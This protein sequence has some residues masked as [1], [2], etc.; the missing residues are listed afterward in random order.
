[1]SRTPCRLA[2]RWNLKSRPKKPVWR[3]LYFPVPE[4]GMAVCLEHNGFGF[5]KGKAYRFHTQVRADQ[6]P[7][8]DVVTVTKDD[9]S[10]DHPITTW[11]F[12]NNQD[13]LFRKSFQII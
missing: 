8:Y 2:T 12:L 9:Y 1:M 13:D 11:V 6:Y 4:S 3:Q 10:E 5:V 7:P